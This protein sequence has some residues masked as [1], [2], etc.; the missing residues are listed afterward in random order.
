MNEQYIID[1]KGAFRSRIIDFLILLITVIAMFLAVFLL[2]ILAYRFNWSTNVLV[3]ITVIGIV[4][5]AVLSEMKLGGFTATDEQVT[6]KVFFMKHSFLFSEIDD[7]QVETRYVI[8]RGRRHTRRYYVE[9]IT[10]TYNGRNKHFCARMEG[11][12]SKFS[13]LKSFI[14]EN[15]F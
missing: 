15:K 7:I 10:I 3:A 11:D 2:A 12:E 1:G 9:R 13:L 4:V 5:W 14:E 8:R 6:F